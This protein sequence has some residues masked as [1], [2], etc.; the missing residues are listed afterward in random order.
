VTV[1]KVLVTG[2]A[3][4]IGAPTCRE[5]LRR[6]YE[7]VALD[8]YSTGSPDRLEPLELEGRFT[9][10]RVDLTDSDAT[11]NAI[12]AVRPSAVI[13]LAARHFIPHCEAHP[14]ETMAINVLGTQHV[15]DAVGPDT[16]IVFASTADVYRP[17][18]TPHM[19]AD[20]VAP[21]GYYGL[22][23]IT[24]EHL[25]RLAQQ[26]GLIAPPRVARFFNVYGPGETNPHVLPDIF[27][28]MGQGDDLA[29]G[30]LE[31]RRD[32]VFVEDVA[33]VVV[34][35]VELDGPEVVVN[36]GTGRSWS[37]ADLVEQLG[38]ISGRP[39]RAVSDP[40]KLRSS[41]RP[42]LRADTRRI[43]TLFPDLQLTPLSEGLRRTLRTIGSEQDVSI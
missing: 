3:G 15:I 32:Y 37:V 42:D 5:L 40:G 8:D 35:L 33:D 14:S 12:T 27:R 28:H 25:V 6:G 36:V 2:G 38:A 9:S 23:K 18:A 19:E 4:F 29:L 43:M 16:R 39:L 7:V 11:R 41:D 22:S 21:V 34:R 31:P 17:S 26:R 1:T 13:H 30:N 24:G 20:D 10:V